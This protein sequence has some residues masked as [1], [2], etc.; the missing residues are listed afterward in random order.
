MRRTLASLLI[1][2][3]ATLAAAAGPARKTKDV[4]KESARTAGHAARD[5]ALTA[6]RT[7]RDFFKG[8]PHAA[9]R[10]WHANAA[11]TKADA[12]AGRAAVKRA[13]HE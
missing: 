8:G 9:K 7:V 10:T 1:A 6:G 12:R 3:V 4:T 13:A 5:G 2:L 11:R